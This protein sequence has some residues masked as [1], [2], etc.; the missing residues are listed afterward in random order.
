MA[1]KQP[2]KVDGITMPDHTPAPSSSPVT[3]PKTDVLSRAKFA[4]LSIVVIPYFLFICWAIF[5]MAV[6]PDPS[7]KWEF[8]IPYGKLSC[9]IAIGILAAA[10]LYMVLRIGKSSNTDDRIRYGGFFRIFFFVFPG[11]LL[12]G[13]TPYL[14][15]QEPTLTLSIASP[16]PGTELVAP[17]SI[18]YSAAS[19]TEILTR[20]GHTVVN[21]SWDF[22]GDGIPNDETV[23]PSSTAYFDRQGG[24]NVTCTI[25]LSNNATRVVRYRTV[26]PNAVFSYTPVVPTID[27]ALRFSVAHLLP[28]KETKVREVQ[29]DFD[30]DG[31]PE[32][33]TTELE[34]THT[35][36]RIGSHTVSVTMVFDNQTQNTF[37]RTLDVQRPAPQPFPVS[38]STTP[39]FLESPSPFQV[40]FYIETDEPLTDVKWNFDDGS[41]EEEGERVGHT[42]KNRR[43]YQVTA[44][45]RNEKGQ[46]AKAT[47]I[48][49][50]VEELTI[51]DLFFDGSHQVSSSNR[52][53]AEA[54]VAID[55][56]PKTNTSL[57]DFWWEAPKASQITSTETT[58]KAIYRDEG[59]Y[60]LVMLAKDAEGRVKRLPITLEVQPKSQQIQFDVKPS[61]GVAP[62]SVQFDA[63]DSFIADPNDDINGFI[64]NFGESENEESKIGSAR[65]LHE[66]K[67]PGEFTVKLTVSTELGKTASATKTVVVRAP[68]LKSCFKMSRQTGPVGMGVAFDR[69]CS[70]GTPVKALWDFG[71]GSQSPVLD[72][73]VIHT[74]GQE[75]DP[76]KQYSVKLTLED[77]NGTTDTFEAFINTQTP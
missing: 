1:D 20:R 15:T 31:V 36:L 28:D 57:I 39:E 23:T 37:T 58:L 2:P 22:T 64:W 24:Y 76:P 44:T 13:M 10:A 72:D 41:L 46:I 71:D 54:P 60:T 77:V 65:I 33:T 52:I 50:V 3:P 19:A 12:C 21:Y 74:F 69:T 17:L 8:L 16:A 70:T 66:F 56:T 45:A 26:I 27:E 35:F 49:R 42:F 14:I 38:I 68:F 29:W 73:T 61:Q 53:V 59:T 75:G 18:T 9:F 7:G 47:K 5:L 51:P 62:L 67:K 48:V 34:T 32:E 63:S 30:N 55:L 43:L 40:V 25:T 4:V 11:A 6:L